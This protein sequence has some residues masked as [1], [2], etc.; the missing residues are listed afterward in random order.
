MSTVT[1]PLTTGWEPDAPLSDS[2][3]RSYVFGHT[4]WFETIARAA[5]GRTI[6]HATWSGADAGG[7][8][9]LFNSATL[10][11]PLSATIADATLDDLEGWF[12]SRETF[13]WSAWPTPDLTHR[14]WQLV[15]HPPLL[16]RRPGGRLPDAHARL[17]VERITDAAGL[18]DWEYVV[19]HG[20]P[21]DDLQGGRPTPFVGDALLD[22]ARVGIWVGYDDDRPVTTGALFIEAGVAQFALAATL[23]EGRRRGY[24][25]TML[26]VRLQAAG[27]VPA[28]ALFSD[29]SRP[30]AEH[31]GF[32]PILRFTCWHRPAPER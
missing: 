1:V 22:D 26:R 11:Q 18:R 13:L 5:G 8:A 2:F 21:I 25:S 16:L 3:L 9:G 31:L 12:D 23:I 20:F 30:G 17:R 7:P 32:I 27:D 14:G 10:L 15:G 24:W 6:R 28:A 19:A 4:A 29:L